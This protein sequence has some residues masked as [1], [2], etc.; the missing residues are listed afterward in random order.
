VA[1]VD[2]SQPG[3]SGSLPLQRL[4]EQLRALDAAD[5]GRH[6]CERSVGPG[7]EVRR[8]QRCRAVS[9]AQ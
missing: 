3:P 8:A 7:R 4:D 2:E 5:V 1:L 6:D 9:A